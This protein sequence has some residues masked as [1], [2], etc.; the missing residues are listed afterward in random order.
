MRGDPTFE[1]FAALRLP[2]L[3]RFASVLTGDRGLA[4]DVVQEVM[5]RVHQRFARFATLEQPDAYL[6][7]TVVNEYLSWRRRWARVVPAAAVPDGPKGA[8]PA[9]AVVLRGSLR[10]ELAKL[11]RRQLA[12]VVL[13]YYEGWTDAEIAVA[14]GCR[15][16]TVRGYIS[17]GLRTLRVRIESDDTHPAPSRAAVPRERE[18]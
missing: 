5:I 17:R 4:E 3:F 2:A 1:Q 12:A 14:L 8:D 6:R 7:R 9:A 15:P 18:V 13:R 16:V 10:A 11:P